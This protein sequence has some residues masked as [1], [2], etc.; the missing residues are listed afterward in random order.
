MAKEA[1]VSVTVWAWEILHFFHF[2]F[3][4][5]IDRYVVNV[6]T[7]LYTAMQVL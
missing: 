3:S 2:T 6:V 5:Y 4:L 1:D 7:V